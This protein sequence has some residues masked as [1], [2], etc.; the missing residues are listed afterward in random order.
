MVT[1]QMYNLQSIIDFNCMEKYNFNRF[2]FEIEGRNMTLVR[3][4]IVS[5]K[6]LAKEHEGKDYSDLT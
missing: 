2:I 5:N 4:K 6:S 3:S 1:K